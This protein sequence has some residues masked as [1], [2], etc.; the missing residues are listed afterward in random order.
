M[1]LRGNTNEIHGT[2]LKIKGNDS[3][4]LINS[5][6]IKVSIGL[7][8]FTKYFKRNIFTLKQI[9]RILIYNCSSRVSCDCYKCQAILYQSFVQLPYL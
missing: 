4:K 8:I 9:F 2:K 6:Q 5:C 7:F 3:M 1:G